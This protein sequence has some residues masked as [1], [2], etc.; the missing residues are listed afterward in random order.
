M[1]YF[2][3]SKALLRTASIV[4]ISMALA[5]ATSASAQNEDEASAQP[6]AIEEQATGLDIIVVTAQKR[7]QNLQDV[8]ISVLAVG[9]EDIER[10]SIA[11]MEDISTSVPN[12]TVRENFIGEN[13]FI[14][15]LGTTS[16]PG[17][18]QSVATF[19]DGAYFGRGKMTLLRFL[20]I[21]RVEVL[22]GPQPTYFGQNAIA[23]A[24][25]I[26]TREPGDRL[27]GFVNLSTA[28][29]DGEYRAE[30]AVGG[31]IA[32]GL[33]ARIA[34]TVSTLGGYYK[35]TAT[36]NDV[37]GIDTWGIRGTVKWEPSAAFD[38]IARYEHGD[39]NQDVSNIQMVN[40]PAGAQGPVAPFEQ[41]SVCAL[42][43]ALVPDLVEF[44]DDD[45]QSSGGV[46]GPNS[47]QPIFST[48]YRKLTYDRAVATANLYLG[49]H[50][51]TSVTAYATYNSDQALDADV[52]PLSF[53]QSLR[54]EDYNQFSQEIR[55]TS[56]TG[57]FLEYMF[58]AY[59]QKSDLSFD[60]T[61]AIG[62]F[63]G[64]AMTEYDESARWLSAFGAITLN[65][66]DRLSIA[67]G[68]RFIDVSK[69][70]SWSASYAAFNNGP[71]GPVQG[72]FEIAAG[73]NSTPIADSVKQNDW[74]P[75]ID[76]KYEVVD[77]VMLYASFKQ[78]F[79]AGGSNP[80]ITNGSSAA[81]FSFGPEEVTAYEAG[82]KGLFFDRSLSLNVAAF[83]SD[84]SGL[85][86][87]SFRGAIGDFVVENAAAATSK[88]IE[89][90][91][92]WRVSTPL[93]VTF[94]VGIVD[95]TY[96]SFPNAQCARAQQV[97]FSIA[98]NLPPVACTQDL[99][100]ARLP[101]AADISASLGADVVLPLSESLN[102][103]FNSN[104]AYNDGYSADIT[105]DP[106]AFQESYWQIDLRA[107]VESDD[108]WQ[109]AIF[110]KNLTDEAPLAQVAN[111]PF[112]PGSY[113]YIRGRDR[114]F[115]AQVGFKF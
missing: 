22:R 77:D 3:Y 79:K 95:A 26:T 97:A 1:R 60:V 94:A 5:S 73:Y 103:R 62:P 91:G 78:G 12:V 110:A 105:N 115:G 66:T 82:I 10:Q 23:G 45:R 40:C 75:S 19:V 17:F 114:Y 55:L 102:V 71:V 76:I 39:V 38:I 25:N 63:N 98:N 7:E 32:D 65:L 9:G 50:T 101:F 80:L 15:G 31:P 112:S 85:Q 48:Q 88:G 109:I 42:S 35:D 44:I 61:T 28:P 24:F 18:E 84:Y 108:G 56:P 74:N 13:N 104:L 47:D 70:T 27:N 87:S 34:G 107:A 41:P 49:D 92:R 99:A 72:A 14:R 2:G 6:E 21:E 58:G 43:L 106:F 68:L 59:Y 20:D 4:G 16:N 53:L 30:G 52:T 29:W 33:S 111:G 46:A 90:D 89:I 11:R 36:G 93:T 64:M 67:A 81:G 86:V 83:W 51:L 54:Y 57:N 100:G 113:A 8:P 69:D 37:P 96:D